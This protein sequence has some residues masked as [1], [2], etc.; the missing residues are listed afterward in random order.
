MKA[1][2]MYLDQDFETAAKSP[3]N[4]AAL[5]QDL[6][7]ETLLRAMG[8]E[9]EYLLG[10]ARKALLASL[11]DPLTIRYRQH[12]LTD[13]LEHPAVIRRAYALAVAAIE[14]ERKIWGW[15]S[16]RR[17]A[18]ATLHR[19]LEV[20]RLFLP[21]LRNL[22]GIAETEGASFKSSGF[23]QL[24]KM[25]SRELGE[26]YLETVEDHLQ[27][28]TFPQGMV[29]S[30]ALGAGNRGT[31]YVLREPPAVLRWW[32]RVR[33]W[34]EHWGEKRPE[35]Y[36]YEVAERDETGHQALADLQRKGIARTAAA[37]A[38]SAE[39]VLHFFAMLRAEL[40]FYIGCLNLHEQLARR[41]LALCLPE[42]LESTHLV[43][44]TQ[45]LYDIALAL[46]LPSGIVV[47]DVNADNK[48]LVMIT[49]ANRGGKST[50]LRS[51]GQAHL[52]M[53]CG[54]FVPATALR[55]G[56]CRGLFTH[57][58]REEDASMRSGK[59]DEELQRMSGIVDRIGPQALLLCN[60]SFG[61]TN[62]REGSEIARQ[63]VRALL[64]REVRVVY[65]THLFEL[66]NS[67]YRSGMAG[68]LFLRAQRLGDGRRTFRID[69]G[70]PL[71]TS[72]GQDLYRKIF[73]ADAQR[74]PRER[75]AKR[76]IPESG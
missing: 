65:V 43:L 9:D 27:R 48:S 68:A 11:T 71:P 30:A 58:K 19:S 74:A 46:K 38:R 3:A 63:I 75:E 60:E 59:L 67:L 37:L 70:E 73:V 18:D 12:I 47:N 20:M 61:S 31:G 13:C 2:L 52:M 45:G 21:M 69:V 42:A 40:G 17:S 32:E 64:E 29:I 6:E 55:A 49:G 62:E 23:V 14:G 72:Y 53:Q 26:S 76:L 51:I 16:L 28:L 50:L 5:V 1:F 8:G 36:V 7:L 22:R 10:V 33:E 66:A 25:L 4:A 44:S 15:T 57:Y 24:W 35:V 39:H 56:V 54:L 41:S 34:Q